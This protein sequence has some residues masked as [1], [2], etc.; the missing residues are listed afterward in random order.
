MKEETRQVYTINP[1]R[2]SHILV[3]IKQPKETNERENKTS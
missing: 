3:I 1:K 2:F